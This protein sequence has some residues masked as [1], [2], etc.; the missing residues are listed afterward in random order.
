MACICALSD[1]EDDGTQYKP[2]SLKTKPSIHDRRFLSSQ[3]RVARHERPHTDH[4]AKDP[5]DLPEGM[6]SKVSR[7][8][9]KDLA[10]GTSF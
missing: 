1:L 4:K 9:Q 5:Y 2:E 10:S 8:S 6:M 3:D 7:S